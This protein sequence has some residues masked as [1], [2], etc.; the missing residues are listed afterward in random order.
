MGHSRGKNECRHRPCTLH[1][2]KLKW[3]IPRV[4]HKI[5]KCKIIE[6][7]CFLCK[8]KKKTKID[9]WGDGYVNELDRESVH[10]LHVHQFITLYTLCI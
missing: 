8:I 2:I 10:N 7:K 1:E 9:M 5:I 6:F 3:I 4:K